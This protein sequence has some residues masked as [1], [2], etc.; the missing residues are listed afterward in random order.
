M[1]SNRQWILAR[2]PVGDIRDGDLTFREEAVPKAGKGQVVVRNEWLSL[3][4][5]NRLWMSDAEQYMP[6]VPVGAPM[7]GFVVGKVVDSGAD[8][9]EVGSYAMGIGS[10]SDYSCE[11][12]AMMSPVP[13]V[14]GISRKDVFG[15]Y[16]IVAPTA[17]FGLLEIGAPRIGETLVVSGAAGAVGCIAVQLGKA[18]GCKVVGIA[19]GKDK[20]AWV[21]DDLG[22]DA[23][24]D[25]KHEN[26]AERLRSLLPEG[27]DIY[28]DN[29]GGETL[30]TVM[31]QMNLFGRVIQCGMISSYNNK[32]GYD[33][34]GNYPLVLMHRLRVQGFIVIDYAARFPEAIR[35]L[36]KLHLEGRLKWRYHEIEGLENAE[37]AVRLLYTGGNTGKMMIKVADVA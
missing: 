22:A 20:C 11:P 24:I 9:F 5:T 28:F 34:P 17:Y 26:V 31:G 27:V 2:R 4:P 25:Y 33:V 37:K 19:G 16:G 14:K 21:K 7:R 36:T 8:A 15:Q 29:V 32:G 18:W 12:V 13:D 35:A 23:V 6:P 3:D 30:N 1:P 10:W